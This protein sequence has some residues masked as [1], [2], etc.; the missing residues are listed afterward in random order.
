MLVLGIELLLLIGV[1]EIV[2]MGKRWMLMVWKGIRMVRVGIVI[3]GIEC[4][5]GIG[6][7]MWIWLM[8]MLMIILG[9]EGLIRCSADSLLGFVIGSIAMNMCWFVIYF[10]NGLYLLGWGLGGL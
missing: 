5:G 1:D 4:F 2:I 7:W 8:L 3:I 9:K 10:F 6:E